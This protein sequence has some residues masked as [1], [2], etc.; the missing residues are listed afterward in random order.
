MTDCKICG[1]SGYIRKRNDVE[2][3]HPE[4]GK[5]EP[6]ECRVEEYPELEDDKPE[7]RKPDLSWLNYTE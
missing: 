6:C 5:L 1:N 7:E 4:F 2:W 3:Y